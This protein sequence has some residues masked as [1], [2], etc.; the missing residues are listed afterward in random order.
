MYEQPKDI[1]LAFLEAL[2]ME[3][4]EQRKD[5]LDRICKQNPDWRVEL[6]SLLETH[7]EAGDFL[8]SPIFAPDDTLGDSPVSEAPGT[9]ID[10]YKLLEKIGEGGMAVVYMAEQEKPIRRKVALKI[11][12]LGMDTK[13]VIARF[14]AE[15]QALALMDHPNIA[16]VLDA[17]ATETGRPYFVMDLVPGLPITEYCDKNRLSIE[18]RLRLFISV[19]NAVQHAHQKGIIHRDIKPSNIIVTQHDGQPVPK[20][21]DFGIAKATNQRLTEKTLFTRHAHIIGTPAYMSPEQAELSDLDV[22]TRTDIYSLGI[23]LYELLTGTT[24]FDDAQLR[25]AGY[26][27]MQKI[28]C[29]Q[30]PTKPSTKLSTLGE[31]LTDVAKWHNCSPA[32]M[33]K[34]VR[35]D[36][37]WIV[38]MALEKKRTR[39][40]DTASA[41][42]MDIQR[43][44]NHEPVQAA[45]PSF[46]YKLRKF[47]IRH[48]VAVTAS[49]LVAVALLA[50]AVIS[51][52]YARYAENARKD[53]VTARQEISVRLVRLAV[54]N[55]MRHQEAGDLLSSL[56][57]FTE[58]LRLDE[59]NAARQELH[60]IQI[61]SALSQC[62]K[63]VRM[64]YHEQP[65]TFQTWSLSL[66]VCINAAFSPD[67]RYVV[68]PSGNMGQDI[69]TAR[70]WDTTTGQVVHV[71]THE[72]P[73]LHAIFS[74]DGRFIATASG[75]YV[76]GNEGFAYV[77]DTQ[78]GERISPG[79]K[80]DGAVLRVSFSPDGGRVATASM[81]KTARVWDVRTGEPITPPIKHAL[82]VSNICFSP[83]GQ[84]VVTAGRVS[85]EG[86]DINGGARIWDAVTGRPLTPPLETSGFGL[87]HASFSPD[88]R[89]IVT[90]GGEARIWDTA[91]G[92]LLTTLPHRDI[93]WHASFS[94]DGRRVVTASADETAQ[95]WDAATG[96]P[97]GA[98]LR[99]LSGVAQASFSPDSRYVVT[100]GW[101]RTARVWETST[102]RPITL[103]LKHGG[104]VM[105]AAFSPDGHRIVTASTDLL[106][107]IWD[108]SNLKRTSRLLRI[109]NLEF[110]GQISAT[111]SPDGR[112]FLTAS[113]DGT[114]RVWNTITFEPVTPQLK[115]KGA[116]HHAVFSRNGL[117][118]LTTSADGT[119]RVW[120]TANGEPISPV[121]K[122]GNGIVFHGSFSPDGSHV[123]TA[124][125]DGTAKVWDVQSGDTIAMFKHNGRVLVARFSPDGDRVLTCSDDATAQIWNAATGIPVI[126]ALEHKSRVIYAV[127]S[128]DG[129]KVL[130]TSTDGTAQIWDAAT[131]E[132][133]GEPLWHGQAVYHGAFS[134]D[135]RRV[136]TT[137]DDNTARVW[138]A[139]TGRPL[140]APFSWQPDNSQYVSFSPDGRLIATA[141]LDGTARV[142]DAATGDPLTS[143]L[144]HGYTH[145]AQ[146]EFS[147]DSKQL[148]TA[149]RDGTVRIWD[150]SPDDRP[151]EDLVLLAR[152]LCGHRIDAT[153]GNLE[154]V[155]PDILRDTWLKLREK[156]PDDFQAGD[157]Q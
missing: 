7:D 103:P 36:L 13:S 52:V 93:V 96:S 81:D 28:I 75:V 101:D 76:G 45:A 87:F 147:P 88:G 34:L 84:S 64:W 110:D 32:M 44:L 43:H 112:R 12:K 121:L 24:P 104:D 69:W 11:I 22:D 118:V 73:V 33:P 95:V 62:P 119:A 61:H 26:L 60:R 80:H 51:T 138:D 65:V 53:A 139:A 111:F 86:T 127:F 50:A 54:A 155:E 74:P 149:C 46:S 109:S 123:V 145:V 6:E 2:E 39:R 48:R 5:Y 67:G 124:G 136:V 141:C 72:L 107:R 35:G 83:D 91:S 115:H 31:T 114:A 78:T 157:T 30:E 77:W 63:L 125:A 98:P 15:R 97:V 82:A 42:A 57:W 148:L 156:Y 120:N 94:P 134:P 4:P 113:S 153:G 130:T 58:A 132:P 152:V 108:L 131:G 27:Q 122:H 106:V 129:H 40:Y 37:D 8:E 102:G 1:K 142:W 71:L 150:L 146:A 68:A 143:A 25:E 135:G 140:T 66:R 105:C 38:M 70:V 144:R 18:E 90:A 21:I 117:R 47:V 116:I 126:A 92:K 23:L 55:G 19:C 29:E 49:S 59:S 10:K 17:G 79:L 56:P 100:A 16:K 3:T 154:P 85:G 14:E 151:V 128:P 133:T 89:R 137:S 99:H 41:L 20:V 9:V